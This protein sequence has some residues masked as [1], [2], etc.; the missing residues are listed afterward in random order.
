MEGFIVSFIYLVVN[1]IL[2]LNRSGFCG[3]FLVI[4]NKKSR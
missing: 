4:R 3:D 1:N 2:I